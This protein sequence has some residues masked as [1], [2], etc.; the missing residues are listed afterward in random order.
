MDIQSNIHLFC[1]TIVEITTTNTA[2]PLLLQ[3]L[4]YLIHASLISI[5]NQQYISVSRDHLSPKIT[6]RRSLR[7]LLNTELTASLPRC[8]SQDFK[9]KDCNTHKSNGSGFCQ[10]HLATGLM[11]PAGLSLQVLSA[12]AFFPTFERKKPGPFH[13]HI[14]FRKI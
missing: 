7:W 14:P 11:T 1:F 4:I 12:H 9:I 2:V 13:F 8:C 5:D 3:T 6:L 10:R